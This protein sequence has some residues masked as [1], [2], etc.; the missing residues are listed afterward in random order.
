MAVNDIVTAHSSVANNASLTIQPGSGA[1]WLIKNIYY[2]GACELYRTDGTNT[3]KIDSDGSAGH[4]LS[5][6]YLL[7]NG[8]Y[9]SLKNVSGG[10]VYMGYDGLVT[11]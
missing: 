8:V 11:K 9:L 6:S 4:R 2:G 1:E 3:I 10:A 5:V 7:T